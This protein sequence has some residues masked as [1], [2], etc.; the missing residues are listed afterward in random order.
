MGSLARKIKRNQI[1]DEFK[2]HPKLKRIKHD[3][4]ESS[5]SKVFHEVVEYEK[6]KQNKNKDK[7]GK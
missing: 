6:N 4:D 7:E 1:K 2:K 3:V 5:F